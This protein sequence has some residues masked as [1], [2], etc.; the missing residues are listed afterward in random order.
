M[1]VKG[2]QDYSVLLLT[3]A[4]DSTMVSKPRFSFKEWT[5]QETEMRPCQ[6]QA[7]ILRNLH[8]SFFTTLPRHQGNSPGQPSGRGETMSNKTSHPSW[9]HLASASSPPTWQAGH[10]RL[11]LSPGETIRNTQCRPASLPI[12]SLVNSCAFTLRFWLLCY[13]LNGNWRKSTYLHFLK[14]AYLGSFPRK[15]FCLKLDVSKYFVWIAHLL[16][17]IFKSSRLKCLPS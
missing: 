3:M 1:G 16:S 7:Q 4:C 12:V 5:K 2:T 9:S 6:F 17:P 10:P 15:L 13:I 11:G 8:S 14:S